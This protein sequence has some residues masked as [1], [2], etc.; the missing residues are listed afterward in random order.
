M[1][2]GVFVGELQLCVAMLVWYVLVK[3]KFNI[4]TNKGRYRAARPLK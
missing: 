1:G 2:V 4:I 3:A